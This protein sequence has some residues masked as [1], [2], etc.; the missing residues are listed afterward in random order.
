MTGSFYLDENANVPYKIGPSLRYANLFKRQSYM[1]NRKN[2]LVLMSYMES[3]AIFTQQIA[4][5]TEPFENLV[6]KFH[7]AAPHPTLRRLIIGSCRIISGDLYDALENIR[8]VIGSASGA[9]LEAIVLGIP[10]IVTRD[11]QNVQFS[12]IPE[13]GRGLLWAEVSS[14]SQ[15]PASIEQLLLASEN[16]RE[17]A[18]DA[19]AKMRKQ[20]FGIEPTAEAIKLAFDL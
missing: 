16:R 2:T 12:Y 3:S 19:R 4:F 11:P 20:C 6:F 17:E 15:V 1:P 7:R 8:F 13:I 10:V 14:A 9:L 5:Q 18:L